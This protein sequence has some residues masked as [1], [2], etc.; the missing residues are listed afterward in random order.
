MTMTLRGNTTRMILMLTMTLTTCGNQ[1]LKTLLWLFV[2]RKKSKILRTRDENED[3]LKK[4]VPKYRL[5]GLKRSSRMIRLKMLQLAI[6]SIK[7][8]KSMKMSVKL[9]K[10]VINFPPSL[11]LSSLKIVK[12]GNFFQKTTRNLNLDTIQLIMIMNLMVALI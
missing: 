4:H 5:C 11:F 1:I 10:M 8:T 2:S 12:S 6:L 7:S 3:D 9:N